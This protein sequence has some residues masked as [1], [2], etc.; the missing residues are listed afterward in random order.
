MALLNS[1]LNTTAFVVSTGRTGTKA[2]ARYLSDCF[3]DVTALHEPKPSRQLRMASTARLAGRKSKEQL[4]S[5]LASSRRT[6]VGDLSTGTYVESN[7]FLYGFVDVLPEVFSQPHLLHVVRDPRTMIRS[8]LN[9]RSQRGIKWVLSSFWP[10]W[11][12]KPELI[13]ANPTRTWNQMSHVERIAWYWATINRHIQQSAAETELP[14]RREK[15][16]DLFQTDGTGIRQLA[17][18]LK[19]KER[20][21]KLDTMLQK[22]VNA[23]QSQEIDLWQDWSQENRDFV[24]QHCGELMSEYG[25]DVD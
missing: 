10:N 23:S 7:P 11:I 25:Y 14:T 15:F 17:D 21:G 9:F 2:I 1:N 19:L 20:P 4:S 3:E 18:W 24:Y 12:I 22:K 6:I 8:A 16:E 13:D 5:L